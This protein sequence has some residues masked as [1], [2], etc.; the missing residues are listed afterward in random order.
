LLQY[1]AVTFGRVVWCNGH[2]SIRT[3]AP[4]KPPS[5]WVVTLALR[6]SWPHFLAGSSESFILKKFLA[7]RIS[8]ARRG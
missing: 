4:Q 7:P 5:E 1:L 2:S 6:P 8:L 3:A